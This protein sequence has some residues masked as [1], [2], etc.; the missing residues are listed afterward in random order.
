MNTP[1]IV[2]GVDES[3]AG[4]AA[5]K[6][7]AH[8]AE[9]TG[10]E[11]R[12]MNIWQVDVS[13]AMSAAEVPWLAYESDARSN[14]ARWVADTIGSES[15]DGTTRRLDV[16]QGSPGPTLVDASRDADMLV[17]GTQV[18]TG[19]SR[20]LFG[21]VSHYCLTHATCVVVAVP[22]CTAIEPVAFES[23]DELVAH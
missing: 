6:W 14:A 8:Q 18:H 3:P 9:V 1:R 20:A 16:V 17:L 7:A 21:S 13:L 22:A 5:L 2:V 4:A 23:A 15:A 10:A 12:I 19:L 11:L